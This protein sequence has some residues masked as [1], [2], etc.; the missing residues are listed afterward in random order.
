MSKSIPISGWHWI[1]YAAHFSGSRRCQFHLSTIVGKYVV[2]TIG[3]Y[4]PIGATKPEC[5]GNE[6]ELYETQVFK[7]D[8]FCECGCGIPSIIPMEL[9]SRRYSLPSQANAGHMKLCQVYA[10]KD[11]QLE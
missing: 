9:T 5:L 1:G 7:Y 6:G 3:E 11:K 4:Y 8:G 10:R 2:S